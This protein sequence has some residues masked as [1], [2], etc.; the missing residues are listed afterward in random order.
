MT[1]T[2]MLDVPR[3]HFKVGESAFS[4]IVS[5]VTALRAMGEKI[6]YRYVMGVSG[7]AFRLY[8][9]P[10]FDPS[11]ASVTSEPVALLGARALGYAF[12][13]YANPS[14][15]EAWRLITQSLEEGR[16][17]PACGVVPPPEW[18]VICGYT[19]RPRKLFVESY[20]DPSPTAPSE[21]AFKKWLGWGRYG[22]VSMPFALLK[23]RGPTPHHHAVAFESLARAVLLAGEFEYW[24]GSGPEGKTHGDLWHSG[25]AAYD[26]W[27]EDLKRAAKPKEV[28]KQLF[29][30]DLTAY[31]LEDARVCAATFMDSLAGEFPSA[32]HYFE[33]AKAAYHEEA[34]TLAAARKI[35]AYPWERHPK[36]R[37]EDVVAFSDPNVRTQWVEALQKAKALDQSAVDQL[38]TAVNALR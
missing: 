18:Q 33:V 35:V 4:P 13:E 16:P 10:G 6:T 36:V 14:E 23:K 9:M 37:A 17:V 21:V 15:A 11:S 3:I 5:L 2:K 30:N 38:G 32:R 29:V 22:M 34:E 19:G 27:A 26:A 28:T 25:L 20:F 8:W 12:Q 1:A 24:S 31:T 7:A